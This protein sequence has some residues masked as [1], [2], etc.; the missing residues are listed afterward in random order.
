VAKQ[1]QVFDALRA[2]IESGELPP[3]ERLNTRAIARLLQVSEIPVREAIRALEGQGLVT[4]TPYAGAVVAGVSP[5][6][7]W[8]VVQIRMVLEPLGTRMATR[9]L[10]PA[11]LAYLRDV[12]EK[13]DE[14]VASGRLDEFMRLDRQFHERLYAR[15][16]NRRLG[17]LL[18]TMRE[19]AARNERL[20]PAAPSLIE[21]SSAEHRAVLAALEAGDAAEVERLVAQHRRTVVTGLAPQVGSDELD[22]LSMEDLL[23]DEATS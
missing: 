17:E 6:E 8:E 23:G 9:H 2:R 21:R 12:I 5:R 14:T 7:F 1:K 15:C 19:G 11:D 22:P 20:V 13:M 16:P 18:R 10:T 4:I 3:G